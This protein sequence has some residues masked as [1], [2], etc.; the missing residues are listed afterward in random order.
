MKYSVRKCSAVHHIFQT[1][2]VER[3]L[4]PAGWQHGRHIR[5][6]ADTSG[7][8]SL[9]LRLPCFLCRLLAT[10]KIRQFREP[11]Q[12]AADEKGPD[13]YQQLERLGIWRG[14]NLQWPG[15][16]WRPTSVASD[17]SRTLRGSMG[18]HARYRTSVTT[19]R[20]VCDLAGQSERTRFSYVS[21]NQYERVQAIRFYLLTILVITSRCDEREPTRV[22]V[23]GRSSL[24]DISV[25]ILYVIITK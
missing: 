10:Q 2:G 3:A 15:R 23:N 8:E 13:C 25:Y 4:F 1:T 17:L 20:I 11:D 5:D 12:H 14:C 21:S 16:A 22:T 18:F 24:F 6:S 9:A 7:P 19:E